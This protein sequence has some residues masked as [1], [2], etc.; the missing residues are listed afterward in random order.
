MTLQTL[1]VLRVMLEAPADPHYGLDVAKS[2]N[3]PTGTVYPILARLEQAGWV[4][5]EFEARSAQELERP[6]RR[7]YSMTGHGAQ[8]ARAEL[9]RARSAMGG[10]GASPSPVPAQGSS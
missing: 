4:H 2:L 8:L 5:S 6:R 1:S 3:L 7:L 9:D 10:A